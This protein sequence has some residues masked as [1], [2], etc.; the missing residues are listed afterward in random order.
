MPDQDSSLHGL[1][2]KSGGLQE[3][4]VPGAP[5]QRVDTATHELDEFVDAKS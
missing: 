5:L 4:L 3:P 2:Q 1:Q